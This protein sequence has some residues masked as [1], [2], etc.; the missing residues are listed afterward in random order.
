MAVQSS[1]SCGWNPR[2]SSIPT[3]RSSMGGRLLRTL[4]G[5]PRL[6]GVGTPALAC[7]HFRRLWIG[8]LP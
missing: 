1:V 5:C 6:G 3:T 2:A 7:R 4:A 8:G